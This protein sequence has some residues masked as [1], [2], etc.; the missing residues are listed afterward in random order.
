MSR[1]PQKLAALR[2]AKQMSQ[3]ELGAMLGV[4]RSAVQQWESGKTM[5]QIQYLQEM[6]RFFGVT[7]SGL[8][9]DEGNGRS[10]DDALREL[11]KDISDALKASFL[12]TIATLKKP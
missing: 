6:S 3:A 5:P 7:V 10:V 4:T 12:S 11:P 8:L 9:G 2:V 1:F